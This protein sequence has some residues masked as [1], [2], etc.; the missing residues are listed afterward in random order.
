M[1]FTP[2]FILFWCLLQEVKYIDIVSVCCSEYGKSKTAFVTFKD[3]RA[4]EIALL[5]SVISLF[6]SYFFLWSCGKL[7]S[8]I[9]DHFHND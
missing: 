4:L 7:S 6:F 1:F 8:L 2:F 9:C 3:P 5:L